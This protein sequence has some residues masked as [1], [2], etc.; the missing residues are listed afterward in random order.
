MTLDMTYQCRPRFDKPVKP[1][2][3]SVPDSRPYFIVHIEPIK[4]QLVQHTD[5]ERKEKEIIM[6][7]LAAI[8][9]I[10]F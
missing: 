9:N 10:I 5:L 6:H 1:E 2:L 3:R 8:Q 7:Y 4:P